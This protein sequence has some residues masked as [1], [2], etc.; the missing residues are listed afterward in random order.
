MDGALVEVPEGQPL[1]D[2]GRG[3][4]RPRNI[5]RE[6]QNWGT[7]PDQLDLLDELDS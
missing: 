4:L 2:T 7:S 5:E 1:P 6:L 3:E